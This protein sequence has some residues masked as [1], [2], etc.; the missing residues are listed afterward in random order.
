[1]VFSIIFKTAYLMCYLLSYTLLRVV[2]SV[3]YLQ[4]SVYFSII[5]INPSI[6]W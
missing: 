3:G 2:V 4:Y 6:L 1:M 5:L